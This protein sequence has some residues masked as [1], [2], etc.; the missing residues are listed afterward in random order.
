MLFTLTRRAMTQ[1]PS[2]TILTWNTLAPVYFRK[3][4]S[5]G[6]EEVEAQMPDFCRGRTKRICSVLASVKA[7]IVC[8]QEHWFNEEQQE[9]YK[10]LCESYGYHYESLQRSGS[11]WEGRSQDGVAILVRREALQVERRQDVKFHSYGIPQDR[12]AL[13]LQLSWRNPSQNSMKAD[14]RLA[15]LC[16]HLT[17]PHSAYD[18]SFRRA[19]IEACVHAAE[20]FAPP[21]MPLVIAG[22]LNGPSTDPVAQVLELKGFRSAWDSIHGKPCQVTH[23][24]H[25]G[26]QFAS[27]HIWARGALTPVLAKLFPSD[28]SDAEALTRPQ[29]GAA[30]AGPDVP[31]SLED[32]CQL[33]DHRPMIAELAWA[34][35]HAHL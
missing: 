34:G 19:Q 2:F 25:R 4:S 7:D 14:I 35:S 20:E 12:V 21:G 17:F 6:L 30:F 28:I 1:T 10:D 18:E 15:I 8:L 33:S 9:F 24:D 3:A 23:C 11:N 26:R 13:L 32:W 16:T 31:V 5:N 22:D 29:L 27:D